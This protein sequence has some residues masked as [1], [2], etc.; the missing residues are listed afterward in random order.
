MAK[1]IIL[2]VDDETQVLNA[3]ERDLRRH[4]GG[5]YRVVKS[6]SGIEA[7]EAVVE[8]IKLKELEMVVKDLH[9]Y[10]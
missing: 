4:Y 9:E 8:K 6:N 10:F 3:I 5:D 2:T 1:P 7:L